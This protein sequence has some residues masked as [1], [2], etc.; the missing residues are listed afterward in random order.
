MQHSL[1]RRPAKSALAVVA[2]FQRRLTNQRV[3]WAKDR[4]TSAFQLSQQRCGQGPSFSRELLAVLSVTSLTAQIH[5]VAAE[6]SRV[7]DYA[8]AV[9]RA[10]KNPLERVEQLNETIRTFMCVIPQVTSSLAPD[11]TLCAFAFGKGKG[12]FADTDAPH[13]LPNQAQ[14]RLQAQHSKLDWQVVR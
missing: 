2:E 4:Q 3:R 5:A 10:V 7:W 12:S 8:E 13:C 11:S 9:L 14:H 6:P 1:D